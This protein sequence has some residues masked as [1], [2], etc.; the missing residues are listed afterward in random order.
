MPTRSNRSSR[1][2]AMPAGAARMTERSWPSIWALR[3]SSWARSVPTRRSTS[4]RL[5]ISPR[6]AGQPACGASVPS[7]RCR[8]RSCSCPSGRSSHVISRSRLTEN[9]VTRPAATRRASRRAPCSGASSAPSLRARQTSQF[10]PGTPLTLTSSPG[11]LTIRPC[12]STGA[13]SAC[14]AEKAPWSRASL[15]RLPMTRVR[16]GCASTRP[17]SSVTIGV[18]EVVPLSWPSTSSS[19]RSRLSRRRTPARTA[20][21]WVPSMIGWVK[22][23][24]GWPEILLSTTL[25][26]WG[27][28]SD[29]VRWKYSRSDTFILVGPACFSSAYIRPRPCGS[30][31]YIIGNRLRRNGWRSANRTRAGPSARVAA[32][33]CGT[34]DARACCRLTTRRDSSAAVRTDSASSC[35]LSRASMACSACVTSTNEV[36][37]MLRP[38]AAMLPRVMRSFSEPE[39][40]RRRC[41]GEGGES[42]GEGRAWVVIEGQRKARL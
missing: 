36:N 24:T 5:P 7:N 21:T 38:R 27:R 17:R 3:S 16:S 6:A 4:P 39:A 29:S 42:G 19:S 2:M 28:R 23:S 35:S 11:C 31:M 20:R 9:S 26:I 14:Q 15:T 33:S 30:A 34:T 22:T 32:S 40:S 12:G 18:V 13:P 41:H 1:T 10:G 8:A 37:A 25:E